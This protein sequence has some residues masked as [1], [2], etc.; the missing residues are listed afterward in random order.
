MISTV[1]MY[2][3]TCWLLGPLCKQDMGR[4]LC[5]RLS[6]HFPCILKK[7]LETV[8]KRKDY[9]LSY[10]QSD[11]QHL[12]GKKRCCVAVLLTITSSQVWHATLYIR[13]VTLKCD[14]E[15]LMYSTKWKVRMLGVHGVTKPQI[16]VPEAIGQPKINEPYKET[17][18]LNAS[19]CMDQSGRTFNR[20]PNAFSTNLVNSYNSVAVR[21]HETNTMSVGF[22]RTT[23]NLNS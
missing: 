6:K 21:F 1:C 5:D 3:F 17:N 22:V 20:N 8:S 14:R 7:H 12:T 19:F 23:I 9:L 15:K 11:Q 2:Q 16:K 13:L 10:K 18:Q 4:H